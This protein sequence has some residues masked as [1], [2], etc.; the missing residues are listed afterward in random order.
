MITTVCLP[1]IFHG[2]QNDE[3]TGRVNKVYFQYLE[4]FILILLNSD[5]GQYTEHAYFENKT[6]IKRRVVKNG[7]KM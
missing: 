5:K 4:Q 7:Y 6:L 1:L 2:S 3:E